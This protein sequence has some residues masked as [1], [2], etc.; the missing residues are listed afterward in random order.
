MATFTNQALLNYNGSVTPSNIVT[1]E[2]TEIL[3]ATKTALA[4]CYFGDC[5]LT[6]VIS[7]VNSGITSLS[8]LS[9]NDNLGAYDFNT[10]TLTPLTYVENSASLFINGV[11][12]PSPA[13]TLTNGV[14]FSN[15]TIPALSNA[16]ILYRVSANEF[17][18]LPTGS[19]ITNTA[20][21]S[22][23]GLINDVVATDTLDVCANPNLEITKALSPSVIN[24][25][26]QITYTITVL[27][28]GNTA[29]V[30]TD[31]LFVSD[32]FNPILNP[33]NV[34]LNGQTL[35]ETTDYTYDTT[36]GQFTTTP[37]VITVPAATYTQDTTT[38]VWTTTPG[39][40][41]LTI[42]GTV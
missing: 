35:T 25:N 39:T 18:P 42:T 23:D 16:M 3:T 2:I 21:I 36:T 19:T 26:G 4:D 33:I 6:Y 29:T 30:A 10:T 41:I 34:S 38:G 24:D 40:S 7:L 12:Q 37:G 31:N 20:T 15:I 5:E 1:G 13:E 32:T 22:G 11:Q 9:V 27:N 17:A 8:G 28:Y 14:T